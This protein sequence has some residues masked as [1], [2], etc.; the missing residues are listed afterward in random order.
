[1]L[2]GADF[3]A[4]VVRH[5]EDPGARVLNLFPFA[6]SGIQAQKDLLRGLLSLRRIETQGEKIS[7]N[8]VAGLFEQTA[9]LI[10]D[11]RTGLFL[12]YQTHELFA[13]RE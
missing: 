11:G 13:G 5:A 12:A 10:L 4:E 2:P 6:Q 9:H 8:V 3:E 1:M 7:V